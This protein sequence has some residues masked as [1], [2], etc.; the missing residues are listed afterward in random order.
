[1][2]I[3]SA[4]ASSLALPSQ[5]L[6]RN[7]PDEGANRRCDR[8]LETRDPLSAIRAFVLFYGIRHELTGQ[9]GNIMKFVE[10]DRPDGTYTFT[11]RLYLVGYCGSNN[12]R[13][14]TPAETVECLLANRHHVAH[15]AE[16]IRDFL[17]PTDVNGSFKPKPQTDA[18]LSGLL[19]T[20]PTSPQYGYFSESILAVQ[21]DLPLDA[22]THLLTPFGLQPILINKI[23][24]RVVFRE[25][26]FN[27]ELET[28]KEPAPDPAAVERGLRLAARSNIM[29]GIYIEQ[30]PALACCPGGGILLHAPHSGFEGQLE[31]DSRRRLSVLALKTRE[32]IARESAQGMF[33]N[34][35]DAQD[36]ICFVQRVLAMRD[37]RRDVKE[38]GINRAQYHVH[39]TIPSRYELNPYSAMLNK[40]LHHLR[41]RKTPL[42]TVVG[43]DEE[44]DLSQPEPDATPVE[45]GSRDRA[46]QYYRL[47]RKRGLGRISLALM[48]RLHRRWQRWV[49]QQ[50]ALVAQQEV[51]VAQQQMVELQQQHEV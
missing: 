4:L 21:H 8:A 41:T 9:G 45:F 44:P 49:G 36:R 6:L 34:L 12:I 10:L 29:A 51:P 26:G 28:K 1:M 18:H 48:R 19:S 42:N 20:H 47:F 15:I 32:F 17:H 40:R 5:L 14:H 7:S 39:Y 11:T 2:S 38:A 31:K 33:F 27:P 35:A 37:E 13:I 16:F 46:W 24:I 25:V 43:I 3:F 30:A 50:Q 23:S 22:C